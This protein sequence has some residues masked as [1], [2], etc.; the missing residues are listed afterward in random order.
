M[1]S[2]RGGTSVWQNTLKTRVISAV[3]DTI[4]ASKRIQNCSVFP[5]INLAQDIV[6]VSDDDD[7][8]DIKDDDDDISGA[9]PKLCTVCA[10]GYIMNTE[11]GCFES[12]Y[13]YK[14]YTF[15]GLIHKG[16]GTRPLWL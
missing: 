8:E 2:E 16:L 1:A 11:H 3:R 4:R 5:V 9:G 7:K 13:F 15:A 6:Q 12:L 10:S 14:I